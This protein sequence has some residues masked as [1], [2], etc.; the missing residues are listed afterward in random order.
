M[1]QGVPQF[2]FMLSFSSGLIWVMDLWEE[3]HRG[4]VTFSTCD[5][6]GIAM[7]MAYH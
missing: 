2:G 3:D 1:L 5:I 7:N 4:E 6:K